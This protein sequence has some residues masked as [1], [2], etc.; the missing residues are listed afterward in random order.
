MIRLGRAAGLEIMPAP[1][2]QR[3]RIGRRYA[4]PSETED[5]LAALVK[6]NRAIDDASRRF[7]VSCASVM[8]KELGDWAG[9]AEFQKDDGT[10]IVYLLRRFVPPPEVFAVAGYATV[11]KSVV[12]LL[13]AS[14]QGPLSDSIA[15]LH[16]LYILSGI[17][18]YYLVNVHFR[19]AYSTAAPLAS[20]RA[21]YLEAQN[22][23]G[24]DASYLASINYIESNFGRNNG[25]SSAGA[26]GP[27]QFLPSTWANWGNGGNINDISQLTPRVM[28]GSPQLS[29]ISR[30]KASSGARPSFFS[31]AR[32]ADHVST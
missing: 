6:A 17:D 11:E 16:S 25:P 20:L 5:F 22:L 15:A 14:V 2:G 7:D 9:T 13:P 4:R 18:Q 12:P 28:L 30:S 27:M 21:Y 1:S 29:R 26:Q 19:Y 31:A 24:V 10:K 8:P 3:I 32:T 23:Y